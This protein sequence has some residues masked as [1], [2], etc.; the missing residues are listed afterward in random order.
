MKML[1]SMIEF[2]LNRSLYFNLKSNEHYNKA[3][4]HNTAA[5]KQPNHEE[6]K[7]KKKS[8]NNLFR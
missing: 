2:A 7:N 8:E 3:E 5:L 6:K 1:K 4:N